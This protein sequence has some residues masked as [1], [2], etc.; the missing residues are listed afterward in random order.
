MKRQGVF[1]LLVSCFSLVLSGCVVRTYS[2]TKDRV[3][4]DLSGGNRGFLKGQPSVVEPAQ[5]K[6][7]RTTQVVE[8]EMRSPVRFEKMPQE[9]AAKKESLGNMIGLV[10]PSTGYATENITPK[11]AEPQ[12]T[13]AV[14]FEKY[15]VGKNDTLQ[16]IS[17]KFYGTTKKWHKIYK[18]NQDALK[19]PDKIY[20]GQ[21]INIPVEAAKDTK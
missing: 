5:R 15:T 11:M 20:P 13:T 9:G 14:S 18:A 6:T 7:K 4:Q 21:V 19:A 16:K 10:E 17:Q 8:I 3:D 1:Y 2:V 12:V